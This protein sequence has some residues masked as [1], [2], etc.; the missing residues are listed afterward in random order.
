MTLAVAAA[1]EAAF[2]RKPTQEEVDRL[3]RVMNVLDVRENDAIMV[4]M[5][6]LEFYNGLYSSMPGRIEVAAK[7]AVR[8]TQETTRRVA[9]TAAQLA[10]SDLVEQLGK[11]VNQVASDTAKKQQWKAL[12]IGIGAASISLL[13]TGWMAFDQ[14]K[15]AGYGAAIKVA[16]NESAAATWANT[17][18]GQLAYRLAL[19]GS[20]QQ[21]ARCSAPGWKVKNGACLPYPDADGSLHGWAL[22]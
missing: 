21:V 1:F 3:A 7:T 4:L 17:P 13:I 20:L 16:R 11:A 2:Q 5:I 6:V 18:E 9:A 10:H 22:P 19:V 12:A 14:G 15:E 8:E